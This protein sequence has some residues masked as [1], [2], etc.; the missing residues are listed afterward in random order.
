MTAVTLT[1]PD[2]WVG[3]LVGAAAMFALVAIV[4]V[5][6]NRGHRDG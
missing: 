1:I 6:Y 4:A 3:V 2:F 5:R